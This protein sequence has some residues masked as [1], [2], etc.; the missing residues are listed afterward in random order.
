MAREDRLTGR[1]TPPPLRIGIDAR[2][3]A[4]VPAGRGRYVRELLRALARLPDDHRY[5]LLA[6]RPWEGAE[7][8]AR[9]RWVCPRARDP[10]WLL[11]AARA[12]E[13]HCDV[14]LATNTYAL[15]VLTRRPAV[16]VVYDL[17]VFDRAMRSPRGSQLERLTLPLAARR[18]RALA[19]ISDA[20][21][22]AL[23]ARLPAVAPRARTIPL[24]AD[25]AFADAAPDDAQVPGRHGIAGPYVLSTATLEPRKNLPRLIEAFAGLPPERRAGAELVL[26]GARG[27]QE[28]ETFAALRRHAGLVRTLGYVEEAELRALYRGATVFAY[29]SLGEG[30]GLPVLEAMTAGVPVL[31]SDR[32]SLPEVAGDAARYVDPTDVGAIRDG[33]AA[34]LADPAERARLAERGRAR[35]AGFSWERTAR[36]TLALLEDAVT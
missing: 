17:V 24:A 12:V 10:L 18:A 33:L 26:A 11:A 1:M 20:T 28:D 32:S 30:F 7:L 27:W 6:R 4:E 14:V 25:P 36:E 13:R 2:A 9:F 5:V 34:L 31:T 8:D 21:R 19:C 15:C 16:A 3:A 23:V 29:P 22:A 35:A